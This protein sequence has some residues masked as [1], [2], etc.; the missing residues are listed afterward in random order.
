MTQFIFTVYDSAANA[1]LAP[2]V[3]KTA[4]LAVRM[5][6]EMCTS[7]GH[8]FNK[9]PADYTLY[10]VGVWDEANG[11]VTE[12]EKVDLGTAIQFLNTQQT[13]IQA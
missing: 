2:F 13:S 5:F 9:F 3:A 8:Q 11:V 10:Q 12:T 6:E 4:G 7:E 1:Y